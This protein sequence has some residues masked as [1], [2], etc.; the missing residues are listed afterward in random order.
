MR[1]RR[2]VIAVSLAALLSQDAHSAEDRQERSPSER[3]VTQAAGQP[4]DAQNAQAGSQAISIGRGDT[5][6]IRVWADEIGNTFSGRYLVN[7]AGSVSLPSIGDVAVEG[8]NTIQAQE[9]IHHLLSTVVSVGGVVSISIAEYAPVFVVG[10]VVHPG[11]VPYHPSMTVFDLALLAGGFPQSGSEDLE[12][13]RN[14][15]LQLDSTRISLVMRRDRLLAEVRGEKTFSP[16][17][18][19]ADPNLK[20]LADTEK[21]ILTAHTRK[22]T[23][24]VELASKQKA[25]ITN[26]IQSLQARIKLNE[27]QIEILADFVEVQ[28]RLAEKGILI[29]EKLEQA[30]LDLIRSRKEELEL[31]TET[32]RAEQH[33]FEIDRA[34]TELTQGMD[35]EALQNLASTELELKK[36]EIQIEGLR[37]LLGLLPPASN[38]A[39]ALGRP[40]TYTLY[41]RSGG[42][43]DAGRN[44][45][46]MATVERGDIV[47]VS[48]RRD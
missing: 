13:T 48:F 2:I 35:L 41:R 34:Q 14:Q 25:R 44:V 19:P 28:G 38:S 20:A 6:D 26:E 3:G 12:S 30:K 5:L 24:S 10:E 39:A 46:E 1:I 33:L 29:R 17:L 4:K 32:I 43:V 21:A 40:A 9:Q 22:L 15:L 27:Q 23:E 16:S 18:T 47:S 42:S 31:Q 8:L 11:A 7:D 36:A 37:V 45:D